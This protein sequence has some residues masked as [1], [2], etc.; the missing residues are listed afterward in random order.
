MPI[1][2][3]RHV[4]TYAYS[5]PVAFGE[6]RIVCRPRE[7]FDQH[8]LAFAADIDP[9]PAEFL[10]SEDAAGNLVGT[11]RFRRRARRLRFE[12]LMRVEQ[13]LCEAR[14]VRIT[15]HAKAAPFSYGAE[16]MPDLARFI[17]RQYPDP[18]HKVDGWAREI[19]AKD[20]E[21]GTWPFLLRLNETI[22]H[23]F[24]YLR[25]EEAGIQ[26]P[27]ATLRN[28]SGSCRDFAVLAC[29]AVRAVGLATRF[30]SGYL[31][32]RAGDAVSLM[33]GG[34]THAWLQVFIPGAGWVDFDPT[35]GTVGNKGLLRLA[36][37]RDPAHAAPLTGSFIGFPS[38]FERMDVAVD[39]SLDGEAEQFEPAMPRPTLSRVVG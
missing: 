29:E 10:W 28:R 32:V 35:S 5:S 27:V 19:L 7:S 12:F 1:Y 31:H 37:V 34:N 15:E 36:A 4:T 16:Q 23:D 6:H 17:E 30:V 33:A 26:D 18:E 13:R 22:R 11:A 25:R 14:D 20:P 9:A 8:V 39:V 2:S 38:D 24:A 21:R 3:V